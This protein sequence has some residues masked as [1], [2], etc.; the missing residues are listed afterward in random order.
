MSDVPATGDDPE[1]PVDPLE[2]LFGTGGLG[3]PGSAG[4]SGAAGN[5][6]GPGGP[7]GVGDLGG[8]GDLPVI[9][10]LMRLLQGGAP[11]ASQARE[12]GRA[13]ASGGASEPNIDPAD[14]IALEQ[15]VR[16]AEL[17]VADAT[18][19]QPAR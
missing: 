9:G 2:A 15:L 17:R 1:D 8:L 5:P 10:D 6:G 13:I 19:L 4:E 12:V 11:G 14:R 16:V 7:G 18:G 3:E